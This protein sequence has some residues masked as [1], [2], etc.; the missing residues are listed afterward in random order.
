MIKKI[1]D[2]YRTGNSGF[3][4]AVKEF[5]AYEYAIL[6]YIYPKC[7][8]NIGL[9]NIKEYNWLLE[10]ATDRR[11]RAVRAVCGIFGY[12]IGINIMKTLGKIRGK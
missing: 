4:V 10:Y 1:A 11:S 7:N 3:N 12:D 5:M 9:S 6:L 2:E 8:S